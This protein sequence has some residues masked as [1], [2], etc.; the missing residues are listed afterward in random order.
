MNWF[1][2]DITNPFFAGYAFECDTDYDFKEKIKS[3]AQSEGTI[4][5]ASKLTEELKLAGI[6]FDRLS[7]SQKSLIDETFDVY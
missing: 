2:A 7:D 4:M 6:D 3:I 5:P 1:D